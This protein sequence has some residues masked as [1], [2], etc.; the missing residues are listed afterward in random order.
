MSKVPSLFMNISGHTIVLLPTGKGKTLNST[1]LRPAATVCSFPQLCIL[2]SCNSYTV[3]DVFP[4]YTTLNYIHS[5][6]PTMQHLATLFSTLPTIRCTPQNA[7][8]SLQCNSA[9]L[10][11]PTAQ[12][13]NSAL[14]KMHFSLLAI[15]HCTDFQFCICQTAI[16]LACNLSLHRF[17]ISALACNLSLLPQDAGYP[18]STDFATWC[19]TE[20]KCNGY[21]QMI[22][23]CDDPQCRM[24]PSS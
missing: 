17:T 6:S 19:Y 7:F 16:Q 4:L 5:R 14:A 12:M 20:A 21:L 8:H 2:H 24:I 9:C 18:P 23:H 1:S 13:P 11:S 10:Q 3:P 15:F 22:P